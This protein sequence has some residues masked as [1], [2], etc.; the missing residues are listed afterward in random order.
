MIWS[1]IRSRYPN[2]W[3]LI[4][5]TNAQTEGD[6]RILD[7]LKVL[8]SFHDSTQA[9]N[10]CAALQAQTPERELYV[11]HTS[12]ETLDVH[13]RR[14]NRWRVAFRVGGH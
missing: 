7:S 13:E 3:L 1:E 11:F 2:Q 4:E 6:M 12:R 10:E 9:L 5:A 14:W 8:A